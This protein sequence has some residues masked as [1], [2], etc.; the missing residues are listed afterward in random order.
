[1]KHEEEM[2]ADDEE[3][4]AMTKTPRTRQART[5]YADDEAAELDEEDKVI[6]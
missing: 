1:M 5:N 6:I 4:E 2:A 3:D